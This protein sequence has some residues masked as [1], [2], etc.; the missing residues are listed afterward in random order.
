[1]R[2][3]IKYALIAMLFVA[4]AFG[5]GFYLTLL[6]LNRGS[7]N[8]LPDNSKTDEYPGERMNILLLGLDA[9]TIGADEEHNRYRSDTMMVFSVDPKEKKVNVLSIPRDTRVRISGVG[10]QKINAAMAYGGPE[11]AVRTVED[12]LGIPIHHY[13]TVNYSGFRKIVD[14]MGG[15]E[16]NIEKRLKYDDNAG[17]LHIDLQP[18]LQVLDGEKAEQFVRFRHYPE[19]DLGRMKAQQKFIE[20]ALKTL[21]KPSTLLRLPQIA[22]AVQESV[23]TDIE[24]MQMMKLANL[25]RQIQQDNVKMYILP[26]EGRYIGGISYFIPYE[27]EMAEVVKEVFYGENANVKVAVLNGSGYAGIA[28]KVAEQLEAMGFTVVRVANADSFDYDTTT[29][30][31]PREKREDAEKIAKVFANA[32]MKEE[33]SPEENLTTIIVGKDAQSD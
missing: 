3:V 18:G 6:R 28:R 12:F 15:I 32:Q 27:S 22:Q 30:I 33:E 26:G 7:E 13:V 16:I 21:L 1:M 23:K 10:F 20:A 24:P 8:T 29:I 25:A 9:G 2:R 17:G 14:A 5:S 11:L 4:L 19:G 31:Y